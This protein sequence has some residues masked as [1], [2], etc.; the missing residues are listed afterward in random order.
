MPHRT[1]GYNS[2]KAL[3]RVMSWAR[4]DSDKYIKDKDLSEFS[5]DI[6]L[7]NLKFPVWYKADYDLD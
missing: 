3:Q 4:N 1:F 5:P 2:A 7:V 6:T